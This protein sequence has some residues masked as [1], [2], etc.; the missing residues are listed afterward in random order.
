M[1]TMKSIYDYIKSLSYEIISKIYTIKSGDAPIKLK[2][3]EIEI[4]L[5]KLKQMRDKLK[6]QLHNIEIKH[7]EYIKKTKM[8]LKQNK[9]EA[10]KQNLYCSKLYKSQIDLYSSMLYKTY[11]E[12]NLLERTKIEN[13]LIKIMEEANNVLVNSQVNIEKFENIQE[14]MNNIRDDHNEL[15]MFF[16]KDSKMFMNISDE[17][18]DLELSLLENQVLSIQYEDISNDEN[19]HLHQASLSKNENKNEGHKMNVMLLN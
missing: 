13:D 17:E 3:T 16:N 10:A 15:I 1:E 7:D 11:E 19:N 12:I 2:I 18:V 4:A 14:E 6:S 8:N 5:I 9:K